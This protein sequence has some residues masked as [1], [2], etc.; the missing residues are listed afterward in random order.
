MNALSIN[1]AA[2]REK[3]GREDVADALRIDDVTVR[4]CHIRRLGELRSNR[5]NNK[6]RGYMGEIVHDG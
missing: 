5:D 2:V 3:E 6:V 1:S 4:E